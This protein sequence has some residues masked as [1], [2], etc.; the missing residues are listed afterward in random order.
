[1]KDAK[2]ILVLTLIILLAFVF[3]FYR[4]KEQFVHK[5]YNEKAESTNVK[6]KLDRFKEKQLLNLY[7]DNVELEDVVLTNFDN[8]EIML[9][10]LLHKPKLF[11][12]FTKKS[13]TVCVESDLKK[14]E[15]LGDSI[16]FENITVISGFGEIVKAKAYLM[17]LG[18]K[19]KC[20]NYTG[21]FNLEMERDTITQPPFFFMSDSRKKV[22]Y[23]YLT[24]D[25]N[26][27]NQDYLNRIKAYFID[28][29]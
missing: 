13:C 28:S 6:F 18:V 23:P 27:F 24:D 25:F 7:S 10:D 20:Y 14:L 2:F 4:L 1:M 22:Y 17:Q 21:R 19:F 11:Y 16:G 29:K 9:Y 5:Y 15:I 26:S 8:E 12:R 3:R